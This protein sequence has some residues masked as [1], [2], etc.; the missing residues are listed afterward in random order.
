MR[1]FESVSAMLGGAIGWSDLES[2]AVTASHA[3]AAIS[4][5][6][7]PE[8]AQ[9][10][11]QK[12]PRRGFGGEAGWPNGSTDAGAT[13][14]KGSTEGVVSDSNWSCMDVY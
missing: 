7:A 2:G 1:P 3:I 6:S 5:S 14:A 11:H 13:G 8:I 4:S 12:R 10:T 9:R